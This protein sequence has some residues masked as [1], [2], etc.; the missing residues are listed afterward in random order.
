MKHRV[1]SVITAAIMLFAS[2]TANA[3]STR[4][5][6][7]DEAIKLGLD[8]SKQLKLSQ[9]RIN[10][11]TAV[12]R[13]SKERRLP[14]LKIT[15]S[16]MRLNQPTVD[17]KIK[18]GGQQSG[19]SEQTGGT[20]ASSPT[21][22][23]AMYGMANLSLP[24]FSGF[25]IQS[26]IESARYLEQASKLDAETDREEVIENTIAA[27]SNLYKARAA[28]D[29]VKENLRQS[30]QRVA[31]FSN[32]E[33]NGILARNDLLKAQL[34]QSNIELALLDAEN[35][36]KITYINM[37]LLLGLPENTELVPD[38]NAF[39]SST[40]AG[41][42]E[43]W[44]STALESRKDAA[45]LA[46]RRKAA[47]IGVKAAKGEYYPS[48]ALTGG[49]IGI[50][51]PNVLTVTNA[52][53]AGVGVSYS[54]SSLW[55]TG[56]KVAQAKARLQ[57]TEI[58]QELLNDGIRLQIAQ[59]YQNYLLNRKKI[60]VYAK[61]VEQSEENYRIVK[62]KYDNALA[63]TTD[64]L[65]ADVAQLQAQLNFAFAKADATVAYNKLQQV[66]GVL[67]NNYSNK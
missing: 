17:L 42:F 43:Q 45:A 31:D 7:L 2:I 11:A 36:W 41:T 30:Q 37:N 27:Y 66:A 50:H 39:V 62:N 49:Y 46:L 63:T 16:Y 1:Y 60:D 28:L 3:Q 22:D 14:D 4:N 23:Q 33:K 65:D 52:I 5:I 55:K 53:N 25:R 56:S 38:S 58:G 13:E 51:V 20:T 26:G 64:L 18:T 12:L 24:I 67:G 19:G 40:D 35:N 21:V 57:Q 48:L 8:N 34:Q 9:A 47:S 6:S 54:P 32:L 10:E 59:A 15:G 44:E 61:A 29:I